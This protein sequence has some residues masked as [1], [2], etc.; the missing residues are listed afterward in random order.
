METGSVSVGAV[1]VVRLVTLLS[2]GT[3]A[4]DAVV[5]LVILLSLGAVVSDVGEAVPK[6]PLQEQRNRQ[7]QVH[8][9]AIRYFFIW[10]ITPFGTRSIRNAKPYVLEYFIEIL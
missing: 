3:V 1:V 10:N 8:K 9:E 2:L 4:S 6:S 5:R 7:K